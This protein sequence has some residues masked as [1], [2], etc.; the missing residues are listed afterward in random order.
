M[1][2]LGDESVEWPVVEPWKLPLPSFIEE[3]YL[4]RFEVERPADVISLEELVARDHAKKE[5]K[6]EAKRQRFAEAGESPRKAE[7][8]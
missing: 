6:R 3:M 8:S 2:L 7:Q 1:N 4:K 5:R